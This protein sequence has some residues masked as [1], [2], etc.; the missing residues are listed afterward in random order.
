MIQGLATLGLRPVII[1]RHF[2]INKGLKRQER[3]ART[4]GK[5][6]WFCLLHV[7]ML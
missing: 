2:S 6:A 7:Y 5:L 1:T 3:L 4:C